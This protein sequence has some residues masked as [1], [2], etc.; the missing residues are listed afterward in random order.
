M[1]PNSFAG[2]NANRDQKANLGPALACSGLIV[3][4]WKRVVVDRWEDGLPCLTRVL[5]HRLERKP[6]EKHNLIAFFFR[7]SRQRETRKLSFVVTA[8][9][10]F[11][12]VR[13]ERR[14][15]LV[16]AERLSCCGSMRAH[17][18]R[19]AIRTKEYRHDA[20]SVEQASRYVLSAAR[21][22]IRRRTIAWI[23][24]QANA[25]Q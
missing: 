21:R 10:P 13:H 9:L 11:A 6:F 15:G 4:E 8:Y 12:R 25:A 18:K 16:V 3:A 14:C 20:T 2:G 19:S 1:I 17:S 7:V 22:P 24:G 5:R 23:A